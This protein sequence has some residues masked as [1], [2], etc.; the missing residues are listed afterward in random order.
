MTGCQIA[1]RLY[2]ILTTHITLGHQK[3]LLR[4]CIYAS[5]AIPKAIKTTRKAQ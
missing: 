1:T 3:S 2:T 5:S 4:E